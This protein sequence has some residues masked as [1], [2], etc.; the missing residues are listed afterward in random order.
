MGGSGTGTPLTT[1]VE[2]L[3]YALGDSNANSY[4]STTFANTYFAVRSGGLAAWTALSTTA[5]KEAY[6]QQACAELD[7]NNFIDN[8]YYD[9]Q[10]LQFP[11]DTHETYSGA[12]ASPGI[13]S[14]K[15]SNLWSSEYN[16]IPTDYFK[17]GAVHITSGTNKGDVRIIASSNRL[18]GMIHVT[19]LS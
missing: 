16:T 3:N 2:S 7:F 12:C 19:V 9:S 17:D 1:T 6:L 13:K 5:S 11:R 18:N 8:K 4:V 15:G 14:F 10:A